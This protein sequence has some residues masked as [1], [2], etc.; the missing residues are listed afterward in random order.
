MYCFDIYIYIYIGTYFVRPAELNEQNSNVKYFLDFVC[1]KR[2]AEVPI[3]CDENHR[4]FWFLS[5]QYLI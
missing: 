2:I 1:H 3:C 5:G 4:T